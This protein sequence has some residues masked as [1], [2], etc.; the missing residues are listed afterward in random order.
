MFK[1]KKPTTEPD[2]MEKA[3]EYAVFLLSLR[4]RTEG[5]VKEKMKG[6]GYNQNVIDNIV[7]QL[8][9]QKYLDDQRYAE[10]FLD[11][12]KKYKNFGFYGIKKKFM[13]KRLPPS[14]IESV[15]A[16]GM[17]IEE[18]AKIAERFIK[19][20]KTLNH[21]SGKPDSGISARLTQKLRARGF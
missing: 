3:Y 4:L 14:V 18:E 11:N 5:E 8:K 2:S 21:S 13:E 16:E 20:G 17:T 9:E 19:K 15:L 12:L 7:G 10:V 6:R 1:A